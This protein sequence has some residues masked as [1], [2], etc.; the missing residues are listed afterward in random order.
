MRPPTKADLTA[1]IAELEA[2]LAETKTALSSRIQQTKDDGRAL[3]KAT[4]DLAAVTSKYETAIGEVRAYAA[5]D[6][7]GLA[8]S[9]C[10]AILEPLGQQKW[11]TAG[12]SI[13]GRDYTTVMRVLTF[14]AHRFGGE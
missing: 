8:Y 7:V 12:H 2:S 9:R 1:R 3:D 13:P 10:V 11:D 6:P 14:L 4:A 5:L